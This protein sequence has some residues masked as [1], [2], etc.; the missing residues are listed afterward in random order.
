MEKY[1]EKDL[2]KL[3]QT[4]QG[5]VGLH[6]QLLETLRFEKDALVAVDLKQI[7]EA[8]LAKEATIESI[9]QAE[10]NRIQ[11]M[12][13]FEEKTLNE[14]ISTFQVAQPKMAEQ[15]RSTYQALKMLLDRTIE[16]NKYNER[17][18]AQALEHVG[19][20]KK[21]VLGESV[22]SASTYTAQGQ[23]TN[24]ASGARLISKEA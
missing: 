18:T 16:A 9:R 7:Q 20:M 2:S 11:I 23:R 3:Y 21:N 4:L 8:V 22:P 24:S 1:L 15:L 10:F 19:N 14:L 12:H 5:L 13:S 17:L 6:R